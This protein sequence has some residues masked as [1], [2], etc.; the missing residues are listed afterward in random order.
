M[1]KIRNKFSHD[2]IDIGYSD[3]DAETTNNGRT[4]TTPDG[5][6]YPSIT[7]VLSI[8]TEDVIRAWKERVGE[9]QAEIV[10]GKAVRRGTKVHSI[11]EKYLNNEDT[12]GFLPH[13][14][15]SLDNLKPV[16]DESIGTVFGLEVPLYSHHLKVAGRCDCIA[17]FNGVPSIIDFK[18]SRYIKKKEKISN[19]FAQGAAYSI[20]WEERTGLI[21]PNVV[22]I[23][24]VD[25]EKPLVF[26]EHR[27]NWTKLLTETIEEYKKRKLFGH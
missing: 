2:K 24:D 11:V 3:L 13:I 21:A 9:E 19:Y 27:D 20:M 18:T 14:R 5:K 12:T 23:M 4:Y 6:R 17:Q 26:V 1:V 22:I 15:Q 10:S 16:L 7:T 25:H 8:L